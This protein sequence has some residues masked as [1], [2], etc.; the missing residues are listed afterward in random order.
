MR[1]IVESV[2]PAENLV[3]IDYHENFSEARDWAQF[4]RDEY[5][6]ETEVYS[7]Y[8]Y[9]ELHHDKFYEQDFE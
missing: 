6:I 5:N 8:D 1:Y 2:C 7:E 3:T 9:M 4:L